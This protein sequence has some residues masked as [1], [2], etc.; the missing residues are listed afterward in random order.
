MKSTSISE[1]VSN[2]EVKDEPRACVKQEQNEYGPASFQPESSL[3][4]TASTKREHPDDMTP[5]K[6]ENA[7]SSSKDQEDDN[8]RHSEGI[9]SFKFT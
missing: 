5:V 2:S 4:I 7:R 1:D 6:Q 9:T 3:V 8:S